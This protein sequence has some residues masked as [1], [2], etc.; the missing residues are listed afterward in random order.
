MTGIV[1]DITATFTI[2]GDDSLSTIFGRY[3]VQAGGARNFVRLRSG[4][5]TLQFTTSQL[6]EFRK[7]NRQ[8]HSRS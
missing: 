1:Y 3:T 5:A 2:K 4:Q 7:N 8:D 6:I